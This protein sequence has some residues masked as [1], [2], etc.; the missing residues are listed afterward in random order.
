MRRVGQAPEGHRPRI[1]PVGAAQDLH[2]RAL[3]RAVLAEQGQD[4]ARLQ[5]ERDPVEGPAGPEALG[6][7]AHRQQRAAHGRLASIPAPSSARSIPT[8]LDSF[9]QKTPSNCPRNRVKRFCAFCW[10]RSEVAPA[11]WSSER[12]DDLGELLLHRVDEP[13]LAL[14][15]AG[16]TDRVSQ[17]DDL[18]FPLEQLPE[19]LGRQ[20]A[21]VVVVGRDEA[22]ILSDSRAESMM[23]TAIPL[24]IA[25]STGSTSARAS[26]GA[27][28]IPSTPEATAFCTSL[29][30]IGPI[31][32]RVRPLP[33]DLDIAQL[34]GRLRAPPRGPTARTRA[35]S[36][37]GSPSPATS[38]SSPRPAPHP[39]G[40]PLEG[41]AAPPPRPV[42]SGSRA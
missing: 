32:L 26:S 23:T 11:Y 4:L 31:V 17:E 24:A 29:D 18:P 1:G 16:R 5:L 39:P 3:A 20:D 33:D 2:Q 22:E 7:V 8:V 14:V 34:L 27:R 25:C 37:W 35:S 40:C 41:D 36:P 28:T 13:L 38:S 10:A 15:G 21:A 6:D 42:P 9:G 19:P 30:L 12:N